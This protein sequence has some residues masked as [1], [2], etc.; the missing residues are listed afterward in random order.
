MVGSSTYV[1]YNY[2]GHPKGCHGVEEEH[3]Y[4]VLV[5]YMAEAW[6]EEG[7]LKK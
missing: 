2:N 6:C 7:V 4:N 5:R 1:D 3:R